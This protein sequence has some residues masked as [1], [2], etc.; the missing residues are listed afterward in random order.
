MSMPPDWIRL[1]AFQSLTWNVSPCVWL[2]D[3]GAA[4]TCEARP[5]L[6]GLGNIDSFSFAGLPGR[7]LWE[8]GTVR[9]YDPAEDVWRIY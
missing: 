1:V 4:T 3:R 7:G 2:R 6:G 8:A 9:L 5:V